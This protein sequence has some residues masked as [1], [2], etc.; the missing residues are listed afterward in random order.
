LREGIAKAGEQRFFGW[1]HLYEPHDP[2]HPRPKYGPQS[3]PAA[4]YTSEIAYIDD[5][6]G[7]FMEWFCEQP[8]ASET[9]VIIIADHGE[10]INDETDGAPFWGHHVHVHNILSTVP[11]YFSGPGLPRDSTRLRLDMSQIDVMPT[12]LDFVG[13]KPAATRHPQG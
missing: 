7:T 8:V 2:Y 3:G 12:I 1:V 10:G 13:A 4:A 6:L 5:Q 9:L 11:A